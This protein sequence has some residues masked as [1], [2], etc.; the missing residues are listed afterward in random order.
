MVV[1]PVMFPPG[2]A[3]LSISPAAIGSVTSIKTMGIVLVAFLSGQGRGSIGRDEHINF[4]TNQLFSQGRES[5]ELTLGV[6]ILENYILTVNIT[7][8]TKFSLERLD[9]ESRRRGTDSEP[10]NLSNFCLL[11]CFG[12]RAAQDEC[13]TD[14]EK[15]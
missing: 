1:N 8:F 7:E 10:T 4:E 2:R 14:G 13:D 3:R 12:A 15:P 5:I 6:S 9:R 11:L